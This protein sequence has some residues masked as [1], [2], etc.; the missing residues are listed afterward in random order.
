MAAIDVPGEGA[1]G[2][3]MNSEMPVTETAPRF[4]NGKTLLTSGSERVSSVAAE[5]DGLKNA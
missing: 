5:L 2:N 1:F 4:E 3:I